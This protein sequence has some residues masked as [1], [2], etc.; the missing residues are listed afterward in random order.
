[1][2]SGALAPG[3]AD[4]ACAMFP[5]TRA[6]RECAL[7]VGTRRGKQGDDGPPDYE[8]H[9]LREQLRVV[10]PPAC[11]GLARGGDERN[12]CHFARNLGER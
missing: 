7:V 2:L 3:R 1:M 4:T 5:H 6:A 12:P 9:L 11:P 10:E 8:R